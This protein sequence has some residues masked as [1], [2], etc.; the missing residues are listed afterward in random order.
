MPAGLVLAWATGLVIVGW[1]SV[2]VQKGPPWPGQLLYASGAFALLALLA[3][4]EQARRLAE[5]IGWG[6][7]LAAF[8]NLG[9]VSPPRLASQGWWQKATSTCVAPG[10]S[11]PWTSGSPGMPC[12]QAA[13]GGSTSTTPTKPG[14]KAPGNP[15]SNPKGFK[16]GCGGNGIYPNAAGACPPGYTKLGNCC[17]IVKT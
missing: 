13:G 6:L 2:K 7:D 1:R 8:M 11:I 14:Q 3:Q 12:G 9:D 10:V 16:T 15:V 17:W 5:T 4:A